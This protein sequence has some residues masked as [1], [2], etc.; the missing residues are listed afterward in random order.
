M[1]AV[2]AANTSIV[3]ATMILMNWIDVSRRHL[4]MSLSS[5]LIA[6]YGAGNLTST[7]DGRFCSSNS[8]GRLVD[9]LESVAYDDTKRKRV[10][11]LWGYS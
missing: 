2:I 8:D 9:Y 6:R 7:V 3:F 11:D 5:R 10:E 1:I 4:L